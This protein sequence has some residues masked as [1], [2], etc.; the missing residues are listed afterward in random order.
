MYDP[1]HY[2][3]EHVVEFGAWVDDHSKAVVAVDVDEDADADS[4]GSDGDCKVG[5]QD[6]ELADWGKIV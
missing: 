1:S 6:S 3:F 5:I 2:H 4:V